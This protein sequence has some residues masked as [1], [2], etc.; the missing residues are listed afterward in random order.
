L[1][2]LCELWSQMTALGVKF[3]AN[4]KW[5]WNYAKV[6]AIPDQHTII[7][8]LPPTWTMRSSQSPMLALSPALFVTVAP[9]KWII[10]SEV[11]LP[12]YMDDDDEVQGPVSSRT[13]IAKKKRIRH[14]W[15][16]IRWLMERKGCQ[17]I[18]VDNGT[19][20]E[21]AYCYSHRTTCSISWCVLKQ[22][23][24]LLIDARIFLDA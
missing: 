20:Q 3:R 5:R 15:R 22:P 14:Q 6:P 16:N 13:I 10:L 18:G 21:N 11:H 4:C 19:F 7:R 23:I 24:R 1:P 8:R 9:T 2:L 12:G 17:R